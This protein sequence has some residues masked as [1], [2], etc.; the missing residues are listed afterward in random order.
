MRGGIVVGPYRAPGLV[1]ERVCAA[2]ASLIL[3]SGVIAGCEPSQEEIRGKIDQ[4]CARLFRDLSELEADPD[5]IW[6]AEE[7]HLAATLTGV[8]GYEVEDVSTKSPA[9]E[10]ASALDALSSAYDDVEGQV[11][12]RDY[13][14]LAQ[15]RVAGEA[16]L[17]DALAAAESLGATDCAGIGV[18]I[19]Y[20]AIAEDGAEAAAA[21][22]APTGDY[23]T[24]VNA[25]CARFAED[26]LGV[27][28][29][30]NLQSLVANDGEVTTD[31]GSYIEAIEDLLVIGTAIETLI[32]ELAVLEPPSGAEAAHTQLIEGYQGALEGVRSVRGGGEVDEIVASAEQVAE[33]AE[34]LGVDCSF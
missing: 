14:S 3:A 25:A 22:I 17:A 4:V 26:T 15:T 8:A 7:A 29:K 23:V 9:D 12:T 34:R 24:D 5:F 28:L 30:L 2:L 20:F 10:F 32:G 11:S 18:R 16:A 1:R 33:A 6:I 13:A 19:G 21:R 27:M 31:A